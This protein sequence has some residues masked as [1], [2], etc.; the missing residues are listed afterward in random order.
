MRGID[1]TRAHVH[2]EMCL[3]MSDHYEGWHHTYSGG[4]NFHGNFNG[5][6]LAGMD[7]AALFLA[8]QKNPE[9]RL[10]DFVLATPAYFKVTIPR[11]GTWDFAER[12][13]W[14]VKGEVS[15]STPSWELSFSA[16]G[17]IVGIAPSQRQVAEPVVT[18]VRNSRVSHRYLTRGLIEGSGDGAALTRSGKQLVALL[19]DD[20]PILPPAVPAPA[21]PGSQPVKKAAAE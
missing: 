2:L 21:A 1:R 12:H 16:T 14:M 11:E 20:F 3:L 9:L 10:Q 6:N 7:V 18:A 5:M 4:T 13:K 8:H 19:T 17:L 15:E